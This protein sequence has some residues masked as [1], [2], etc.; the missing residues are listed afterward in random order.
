MLDDIKYCA[1]LY[2][3]IG[4]YAARRFC[5]KRGIDYRLVLLAVKLRAGNNAL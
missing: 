1:A 5:E 2:F 4:R 3:T